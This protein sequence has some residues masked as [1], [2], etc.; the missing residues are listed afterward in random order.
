MRRYTDTV[1]GLNSQMISIKHGV[2]VIHYFYHLIRGNECRNTQFNNGAKKLEVLLVF[3][4]YSYLA[5]S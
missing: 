5:S 2:D 1:T 4:D 3:A